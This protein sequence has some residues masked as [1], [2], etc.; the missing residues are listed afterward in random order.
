M[1]LVVD[2]RAIRPCHAATRAYQGMSARDA[3]AL[4][5]LSCERRARHSGE[6]PR[7]T[8]IRFIDYSAFASSWMVFMMSSSIS[9]KSVHGVVEHGALALVAALAQHAERQ[10][11]RAVVGVGHDELLFARVV[12]LDEQAVVHGHFAAQR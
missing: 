7:V 6:T 9:G 2:A 12:V 11:D 10:D 3:P 1:D 8:R 5:R 4:K